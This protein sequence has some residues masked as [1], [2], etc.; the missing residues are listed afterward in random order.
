MWLLPSLYSFLFFLYDILCAIT[1][2][3]DRGLYISSSIF[4]LALGLTL[5]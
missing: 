4:Y 2:M 5:M 1:E 3:V